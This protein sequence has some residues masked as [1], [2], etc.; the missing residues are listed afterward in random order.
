MNTLDQS[1][2]DYCRMLSLPVVAA[3]YQKEAEE[4]AKAKIS[5]QEYLYKV[6]QQQVIVRVDNSVNTKIKKARFPFIA[7]LE[8][9]DFAYQ[10]NID[11]RL[12]RELA[13]LHFLAQAKNIIFIGPPGVGKTHLAVAIGMKAV[14]ARKRVSMYSAEDLVHELMVH[15]VSHRLSS[16]LDTISR[17]D[18]LIIDELGY[19]ALSKESAALFFKLI[20]KRYEKTSTIITSNKPFE[21]WG[22]IFGDEVV[23]AA[24][25]DRLLHHCYP[26]FIQG[27]SYRLKEMM[28]TKKEP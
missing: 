10:P 20:S 18:L 1:I 22:E 19:L 24:I 5:Y 9:Y 13:T 26:F 4:A 27:K 23:A 16:F 3:H 8:G 6:L 7:T 25:L 21:E 2:K 15:D 28:G 12:I 14:Q 11:E 17:I